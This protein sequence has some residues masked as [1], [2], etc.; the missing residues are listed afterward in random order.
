MLKN[1]LFAKDLSNFD[2]NHLEFSQHEKNIILLVY[3]CKHIIANVIYNI[4][5]IGLNMQKT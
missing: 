2:S 1:S 3:S 4:E 5:H